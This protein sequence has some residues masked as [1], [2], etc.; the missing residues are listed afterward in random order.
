VKVVSNLNGMEGAV[1]D[2]FGANPSLKPDEKIIKINV[3][4]NMTKM[5]RWFLK[6]FL[7]ILW[8]QQVMR[9]ML[10]LNNSPVIFPPVDL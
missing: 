6:K 4:Q 10:P 9:I 7:H 3:Q 8:K 2:L 5:K 1:F